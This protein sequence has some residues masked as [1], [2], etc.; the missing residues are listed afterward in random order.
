MGRSSTTRKPLEDGDELALLLEKVLVDQHE[1]L[2]KRLDL[3]ISSLATILE[4][5]GCWP[6]EWHLF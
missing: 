6:Q 1:L 2:L 4:S 3:R 5:K